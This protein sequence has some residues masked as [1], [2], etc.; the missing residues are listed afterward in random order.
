LRHTCP[1]VSPEKKSTD[2]P[3]ALQ[4]AVGFL[5]RR[6]HSCHELYYKL[7]ERG[8]QEVEIEEALVRL[9]DEGL[10][11]DERFAEAFVQSRVQRGHGPVKIGSELRQR[12]I[13]DRLVGQLIQSGV[14]DWFELAGQTYSKK[15][16]NSRPADYQEKARRMRFL[17][18][19]GFDTEQC[20]E[21]IERT[22]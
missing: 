4:R 19:R 8:Y 20:R 13:D 17:Q 1:A 7:S 10:Q 21:A 9:Q 3:T 12:G 6:E 14:Y 5:A 2:Q 18:Q 16:G 22:A 11:S 15:Y